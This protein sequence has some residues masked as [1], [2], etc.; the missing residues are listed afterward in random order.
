MVTD[1]E[2]F[3][4][5]SLFSPKEM[6]SLTSSSLLNN[7]YTK[8]SVFFIFPNTGI[9]EESMLSTGSTPQYLLKLL[10]FSKEGVAKVKNL[11]LRSP[12]L[13]LREEVSSYSLYTQL[14]YEVTNAIGYADFAKFA[15]YLCA[16]LV[17]LN[18]YIYK[19]KL[20]VEEK[21]GKIYYELL[22]EDS[23]V[24]L[25]KDYEGEV[26]LFK[27]G[28]L[29]MFKKV[30]EESQYDYTRPSGGPARKDSSG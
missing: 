5:Q 6:E 22:E 9:I 11:F 8:N 24:G 19:F 25:L 4:F 20:E 12:T 7:L 10:I 2:R 27:G 18:L 26:D 1:K 16:G 28:L 29:T 13:V 14:T 21:T 3:G 30:L 17:D 15:D 23:F